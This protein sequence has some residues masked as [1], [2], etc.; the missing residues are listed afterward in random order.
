MPSGDPSM[1]QD[2]GRPTTRAI[3][4]RRTVGS[5]PIALALGAWAIA[6]ACY[7]AYYAAGGTFGMIGVPRSDS[8]FRIINAVGATVIL[9]A[10]VV[11]VVLVRLRVR[12]TALAALAWLVAVGCCMH[13]VVDGTLRVLSLVGLHP[14]QLP[15]AVWVSVDRRAADLL[16]LLLNEAGSR[17]CCGPR[18]APAWSRHSVGAPGC[19]RPSPRACC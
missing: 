10:A 12:A 2:R 19:G 11:P 1:V 13:A 4:H 18:S 8:Q 14:T 6:Y 16:D 15:S 7:R 9:L 5:W 17:V 3:S